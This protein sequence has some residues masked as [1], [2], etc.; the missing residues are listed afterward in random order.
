M[1]VLAIAS[2]QLI[3][4]GGLLVA[5]VLLASLAIAGRD[6]WGTALRTH[7][8]LV[9][10][11]LVA[12]VIAVGVALLIAHH[13]AFE[14]V[15]T[16]VENASPAWVAAG[17]G[18]EVLSFAGYVVLVRLFYSPA[19]PRLTTGACVELTLGGV[20]ATRLFSAGGAGG[21]AFTAW[22]LHRAGT[23]VRQTGRLIAAFLAS[24]Y[25][26]YMLALL[27][28]GAVVTIG[29]AGGAPVALGTV[30]MVVGGVV[31]A[32]ALAAARIP[33]D[34]EARAGK[35]AG[36][37]GRI[38]R[39][40]V[41]LTALPETAGDALRLAHSALRER[42]WPLSAAVAA[43]WVF[44]IAVLWAAFKAFG[45]PPAPLTI[46]LC[47]FLGTFGN[48][49]PL[50]GGVGGTEGGMLGAFVACGVD[51]GLALLAV[52]TYQVISTYLPA[53]PG[54]GAYLSLRRRMRGWP[55]PD[56]PEGNGSPGELPSRSRRLTPSG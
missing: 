43:W 35:I 54:L 4:L 49:L 41:R 13:Q 21:I 33:G 19:A 17:I 37:P 48:L 1:P 32:L 22:V 46:V 27:L 10:R 50:P 9:L 3:V 16:R 26:F 30:A 24:L 56:R 39:L 23:G 38:G 53:L 40:G 12:A 11:I 52:L 2:Q 31:I 45:E 42:P 20:A 47:Y 5:A 34:L 44:D 18:L 29:L 14:Q 55:E 36:R 15:V 6:R 8:K 28:G 51:A 25:S 7:Q